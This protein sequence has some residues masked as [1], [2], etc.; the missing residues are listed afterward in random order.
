MHMHTYTLPIT[1]EEKRTI[2]EDR[3]IGHR[4]I[5]SLLPDDI[6]DNEA[7]RADA[8]TMWE[9]RDNALVIY[10]RT[11]L[12]EGGPAKHTGEIAVDREEMEVVALEGDVTLL[13]TPTAH[14]PDELWSS[15]FRPKSGTKVP[16]PEDKRDE[17]LRER[18]AKRGFAPI[19][20]TI[21]G[22]GKARI[23]KNRGKY[24]L[25]YITFRAFGK[26]SDPIAFRDLLTNGFGKGKNYGLGCVATKAQVL[27]VVSANAGE[28]HV[29]M[30]VHAFTR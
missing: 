21:T 3:A 30:P 23:G 6:L 1:K 24:T 29:T 9:L 15:G 13:W 7:P 5:M 20:I 2:Q 22:G 12:A 8:G 25:P 27:G 28:E 16:V 19:S 17:V 4:L 11:P 14:V 18:L 10:T 26:V